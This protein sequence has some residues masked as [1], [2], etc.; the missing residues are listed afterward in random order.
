MQL[1]KNH[2][3]LFALILILVLVAAGLI[4]NFISVYK[5]QTVTIE[6]IIE[7]KYLETKL[8][9]VLIETH[10]TLLQEELT[11]SGKLF[12]SNNLDLSHC[13]SKEISP[14]TP[15]LYA[16]E[17][18]QVVGC[19]SIDLADY[20]NLNIK[21]KDYFQIPFQTQQPY[22]SAQI[23]Q[24]TSR[25]LIVS[26]P[27][28]ETI[29]YTTSQSV[30]GSFRGVMFSVVDIDTLNFLYLTPVLN[31][32]E[33]SFIL[34]DQKSKEVIVQSEDVERYGSFDEI[35]RNTKSQTTIDLPHGPTIITSTT[36]LIGSEEWQLIILTPIEQV[37]REFYTIQQQYFILFFLMSVAIAGTFIFTYILYRSK[38][39]VEV[40][41][42]QAQS[43]LEKLGIHS[44]AEEHKFTQADFHLQPNQIYL[45]TDQQEN[46]AFELFIDSLNQGHTGLG[47]IRANPDEIKK[48]YHL[49]KTPFI[50]L[51]PQ[52]IQ[53]VISETE[54]NSVSGIIEEFVTKHAKS[55]ILLDGMDYLLLQNPLELILDKMYKWQ[56]LVT[57]HSAIIIITL[58]QDLIDQTKVKAIQALTVDVYGRSLKENIDLAPIERDILQLINEKNS[59]NTLVSYKDI[60][61]QFNITKPTTRTKIARLQSLGLVNIEQ[62]GRYKSLK[63]TS[64]GR[65]VI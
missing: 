15:I 16:N 53:N 48:K 39:K 44:A 13:Q 3:W 34:L 12:F 21:E 43:T 63:I 61:Q 37:A 22:V 59:T 52:K 28:Y 4:A 27:L 57:S 65:K 50:W 42:E 54:V 62:L 41:L 1:P 14:Q 60:T 30:V 55:V 7:N 10:I 25:Q 9:G 47:I 19:T 6:Q 11:Q 46:H 24:G 29:T 64:R 2:I 40:K 51:S 31:N 5:I 20:A 38:Q 32:Q 33:S 8:A 45:I 36:L 18:G 56:D 23:K 49:Q 35:T 26:V 17:E 58:N